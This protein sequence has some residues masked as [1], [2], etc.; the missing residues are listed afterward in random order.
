MDDNGIRVS[1]PESMCVKLLDKLLVA[2]EKPMK[3]FIASRDPMHKGLT[4]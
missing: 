2:D 1:I 4:S 3:I